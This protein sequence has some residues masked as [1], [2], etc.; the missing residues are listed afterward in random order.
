MFST[1]EEKK[2]TNKSEN[3]YAADIIFKIGFCFLAAMDVTQK[4]PVLKQTVRLHQFQKSNQ[5]A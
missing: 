1:L 4:G 2:K 5:N 3:I